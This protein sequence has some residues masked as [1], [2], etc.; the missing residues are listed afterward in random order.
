METLTRDVSLPKCVFVSDTKWK[1][2]VVYPLATSDWEIPLN[3]HHLCYSLLW[4]WWI[5]PVT[6]VDPSLLLLSAEKESWYYENASI[7]GFV[8]PGFFW[9]GRDGWCERYTLQSLWRSRKALDE[10]WK[11]RQK[12]TEAIFLSHLFVITRLCVSPWK[13]E[14]HTA[15]T[16][17]H[18]SWKCRAAVMS[19][20]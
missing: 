9:G 15:V 7:L 16:A 5:F 4:R 2:L 3:S 19:S 6:W 8:Q 17:E 11:M 13:I 14:N 1:H 18:C 20:L 10:C 12:Q